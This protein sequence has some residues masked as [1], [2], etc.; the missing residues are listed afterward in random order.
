[1]KIL[2]YVEREVHMLS[3][4]V[5]AKMGPVNNNAPPTPVNTTPAIT[6]PL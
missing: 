2:G 4:P 6:C 3:E 1:M 5:I